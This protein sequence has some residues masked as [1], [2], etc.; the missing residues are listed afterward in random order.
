[1]TS[2][3]YLTLLVAVREVRVSLETKLLPDKLWTQ[4]ETLKKFDSLPLKTMWAVTIKT[5]RSGFVF[6]VSTMIRGS[7]ASRPVQMAFFRWCCYFEWATS[8]WVPW[9]LLS[10]LWQQ[11]VSKCLGEGNQWQELASTEMYLPAATGAALVAEEI[12][13]IRWHVGCHVILAN[14]EWVIT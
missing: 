7:V 3:L 12:E 10:L 6:M 11:C 1:M 5:N 9:F 13:E 4:I 8:V 14:L 2:S